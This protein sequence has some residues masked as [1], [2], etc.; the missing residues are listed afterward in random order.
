[1][2]ETNGTTPLGDN[3]L[4]KFAHHPYEVSQRVNTYSVFGALPR[5]VQTEM[6]RNLLFIVNNCF[7]LP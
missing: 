4:D 3:S 2:I 1:M 7:S 6:V 5:G